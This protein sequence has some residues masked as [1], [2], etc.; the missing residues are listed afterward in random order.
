MAPISPRCDRINSP[1]TKEQSTWGILQYGSLRNCLA[2]RR[3]FRNHFK[4]ASF[5][6]PHINSFKRLVDRFTKTGDVRAQ[7][8]TG[9]TAELSDALVEEVENFLLPYTT[10]KKNVSLRT[11]AMS[12]NISYS[13]A[14]RVV[15]KKLG[16]Y[17]YKPRNV[18]PLTEQHKADR[19]LFC[20]WLLSQ[21]EDLSRKSSGQMR[22]GSSSNRNPTNRMRD[23]GI[24]VTLEWRLSAES[25]VEKKGLQWRKSSGP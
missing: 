1:I 9:G 17:P 25:K 22:N 11:L 18:I 19:V 14:W 23:T 24:L 16:W 5:K 6:V 13:T 12:L 8:K 7:S 20:D 2:V 4:L 15:R 10:E 3:K 21:E